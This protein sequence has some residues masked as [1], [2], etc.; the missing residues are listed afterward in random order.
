[1]V[2]GENAFENLYDDS[3]ARGAQLALCQALRLLT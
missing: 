2:L 3:F 1:M